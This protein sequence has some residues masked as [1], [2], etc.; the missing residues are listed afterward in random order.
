MELTDHMVSPSE[1]ATNN[2]S[3]DFFL[4][5]NILGKIYFVTIS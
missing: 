1:S 4:A 5:K 2:S 3:H